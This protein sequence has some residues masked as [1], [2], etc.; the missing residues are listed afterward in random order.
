MDV[1]KD[2]TVYV[3]VKILPPISIL[4]G[5]MLMRYLKNKK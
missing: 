1:L 3:I 2:Y 5:Y 4:L